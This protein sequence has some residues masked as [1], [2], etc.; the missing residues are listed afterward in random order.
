LGL[1]EKGKE[2]AAVSGL[3]QLNGSLPAQL[4][5]KPVNDE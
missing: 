5:Q 1:D 3:G 2:G 4:Q